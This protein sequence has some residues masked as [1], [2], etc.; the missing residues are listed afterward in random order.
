MYNTLLTKGNFSNKPSISSRYKLIYDDEGN[1]LGG[2]SNRYICDL[3]GVKIAS[4][5]CKEVNGSSKKKQSVFTSNDGTYRFVG[6]A[7]FLNDVRIGVTKSGP[8][9]SSVMLLVVTMLLLVITFGIVS[10]IEVPNV[11]TPEIVLNDNDG[12]IDVERKIGVFDP[13]IAPNSQGEYY[14][15]INNENGRRMS[16]SFDVKEYY[17]GKE[18]K[19]FPM[20]Y[21]I[22]MNN[23]YMQNDSTWVTS[24][25]LSFKNLYIAPISVQEFTLEWLWPFESGNDALDTYYGNDNGEYSIVISLKAEFA[26]GE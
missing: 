11:D 20:R 22:K 10:I 6:N 26:E 8:S 12:V 14:F 7:L 16:Y 24:D 13:S 15:N 3:N 21:R 1:I 19:N 5:A 9:K 17:N 2:I 4:F 25:E 23:L 18:V